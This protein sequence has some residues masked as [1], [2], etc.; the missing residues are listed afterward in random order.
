MV[1][2]SGAKLISEDAIETLKQK[3]LLPIGSC[4][5]TEY[6]GGRSS[7]RNGDS[8]SAEDMIEAAE[9]DIRDLSLCGALQRRPSVK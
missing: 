5:D 1:A 4:S 7:G 3:R 6:S 9:T 2:T 8:L